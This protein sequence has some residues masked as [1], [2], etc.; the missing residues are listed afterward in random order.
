MSS[1]DKLNL[2]L[3]LHQTVLNTED[4]SVALN[5][6][7]PEV[8]IQLGNVGLNYKFI[9]VVFFDSNGV[10]THKFLSDIYSQ[11]PKVVSLQNIVNLNAIFSNFSVFT[12]Q[13]RKQ[14]LM[15]LSELDNVIAENYR[16]YYQL[17]SLTVCPVWAKNKIYGLVLLG[18]ERGGKDIKKDEV[19][20]ID[21]IS[22]IVSLSYRIQET[23]NSLTYVT[24][25]IYKM[26]TKLHELDRLKD[27]F[28]SIA[29][30]E[31]R[32]PMTAI[33]SYVWMALHKSEMPLNQ[34]MQRYLY[35]TLV[36]TERLINMVNDMLNISR[37]ES[38]RVQITPKV[39]D[40]QQLCNEILTE[41]DIKA[42]EKNIKVQIIP[43]NTLPK[44]FADPDK[45]HQ[46]MLNLVGNALKFT[47]ENGTITFS[48]FSDG[49]FVDVSIKDT[50]VGISKE[51]Q[52]QLFTKFGRL[53]S[54]YQATS[55][56]GGTGLG[57]YICKSLI[58]MMK[59][60]IGVS[61]QG[62]GKGT[63]FTFAL[64]IASKEVLN[65]SKLYQYNPG[66]EAKG[67]EPVAI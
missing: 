42:K 38:G 50:G 26:N 65:N 17:K 60:R 1:V 34:K 9:E 5:N 18:S 14:R 54:S 29:S 27:E 46:V 51:E 33:R 49:K 19:E 66:G 40:I 62:P 4:E 53:E 37:I 20:L 45:T 43:D 41:I 2:F 8:L 28:V 3:T 22:T 7:L 52:H 21:M 56:S 10:L 57:L 64:P 24:Q 35:R 30:H 25:E 63:T 48:F 23:Q 12:D 31:L 47:S 32:T 36:S 55:S 44:V 13:L 67:L 6:L 59:G 11:N 16:N 15:I 61:S 58:E 39:F